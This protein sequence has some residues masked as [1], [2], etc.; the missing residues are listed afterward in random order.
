MCLYVLPAVVKQPFTNRPTPKASKQ[1][2]G[3]AA[4]S[5][6]QISLGLLG[7]DF[8]FLFAGTFLHFRQPDRNHSVFRSGR[9]LIGINSGR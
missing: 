9:H 1:P 4:A 6:I 7:F 3:L 5:D 2:L 8:H